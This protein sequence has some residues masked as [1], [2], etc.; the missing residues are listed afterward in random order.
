MRRRRKHQSV[1]INR[2]G[3][4][5]DDSELVSSALLWDVVRLETLRHSQKKKEMEIYSEV[6]YIEKREREIR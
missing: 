1:E 5:D 4:C 3:G 2:L 6:D